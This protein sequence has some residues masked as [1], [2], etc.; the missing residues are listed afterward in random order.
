MDKEVIQTNIKRV[1]DTWE[2]SLQWQLFICA[3]L[4]LDF[5]MVGLA[6]RL[7]YLIRFE[8]GIPLFKLEVV[9]SINY[10]MNLVYI[11]IP[12]WLVLF[13]LFGLYNRQNLLG[14]TK[15]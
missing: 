8:A 12:G 6:F 1:T 3:L 5:L 13:A 15:E 2:H 4:I 11:L 10:Y 14:G 7:A 9:P